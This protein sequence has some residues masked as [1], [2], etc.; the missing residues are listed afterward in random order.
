MT[1]CPECD[2]EVNVPVDVMQDELI[3][4]QCCGTELQY[5]GNK[6]EVADII[7]IDWGE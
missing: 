4:C 1:K 3:T 6:L 2:G 5:K 7:A